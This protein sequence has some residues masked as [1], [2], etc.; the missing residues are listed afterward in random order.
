M[1]L[2]SANWLHMSIVWEVPFWNCTFLKGKSYFL[3]N[4][5]FDAGS[6]SIRDCWIIPIPANLLVLRVI[7]KDVQGQAAISVAVTH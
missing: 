2:A 6:Y 1:I 3:Y 4:K 7:N 5:F